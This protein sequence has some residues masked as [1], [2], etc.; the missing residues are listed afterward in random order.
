MDGL[1]RFSSECERAGK[2]NSNNTGWQFWQQHNQPIE[3][4]NKKMFAEIV[5]YTHQN[6]VVSGFVYEEEQWVYSSAKNYAENDGVINLA[7]FY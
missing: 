6:P 2:K 4:L 5:F 1:S 7:E 3:I